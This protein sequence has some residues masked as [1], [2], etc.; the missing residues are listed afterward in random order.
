MLNT[1]IKHEK[2]RQNTQKSNVIRC[3][4]A[5]GKLK[6]MDIHQEKGASKWLS[7]SQLKGEGYYFNKQ[8]FWYLVKL[9]HSCSLSLLSTQCICGAQNYVQHAFSCKKIRFCSPETQS[10]QECNHWITHSSYQFVLAPH[11]FTGSLY[12]IWFVNCKTIELVLIITCLGG[13]FGTNCPS[14]FLKIL[15]LPKSLCEKQ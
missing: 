4:L 12:L 13:W 15:K 6:L 3:C 10:Y 1:N 5:D 7:T 14:A 11:D 9:R 8:E 2:L